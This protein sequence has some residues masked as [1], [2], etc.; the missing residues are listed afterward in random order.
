MGSAMCGFLARAGDGLLDGPEFSAEF[1]EIAG[2]EGVR[3]GAGLDP[4]GD[5]AAAAGSG[6][7]LDQVAGEVP[8]C[9]IQFGSLSRGDRIL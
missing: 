8:P 2:D 5:V 3:A 1:G 4:A 6:F 9:G 7:Y